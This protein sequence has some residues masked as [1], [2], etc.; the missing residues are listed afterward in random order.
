MGKTFEALKKAESEHVVSARETRV[1]LS[2][3]D[4]KPHMPLKL[5]LSS[6]TIEEYHRLRQNVLL[7]DPETDSV[8]LLFVS[9]TEGEGTT[10]VMVQF[11]STLASSGERVVLVDANF[12]HPTLHEVFNVERT[13]G[14]S[15][16]LTQKSP[17][18]NVIR[19]TG[20]RNLFVIPNGKPLTDPSSLLASS[21]TE[22]VLKQLRE[23]GQWI[24]FDCAPVT[25]YSDGVALAPK[26]DGVVMIIEAERTKREVAKYAKERLL[27][28]NAKILGTILNR[29]KMHIPEW[30]Y[31][32][33]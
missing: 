23:E 21:A 8:S 17:P 26:V 22:E 5:R 6:N 14:F 12:R 27:A 1:L 3:V 33:L 10:T 9:P 29:R 11:A 20:F 31:R 19:E 4:T 24:L 25:P 32:R 2:H 30:L 7:A 18:K 15:E 13:S 28:P 16:L